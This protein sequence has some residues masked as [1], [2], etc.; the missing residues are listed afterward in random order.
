M[1][2]FVPEGLPEGAPL[3]V[4]L[5][6]CT[7]NAAGYDRGCGWSDL[8]RQLGFAL[9]LPEQ[10]QA[11][12]PNR[13]FNW[14]E[15]GDTARDAGEAA[16]IRQMVAHMLAAHRLDP[17]RVF[18]T[19]LSA[20]GA[21]TSVMLATYP[22]VFAAGAIIAG[23][24]H[25]AASNMQEAFEAMASGRPR[26]A[27]GWGDLVRAASPH[28]GP[29]PRVSVWQGEAD[30][31]VRPVN[32]EQILRQWT[33]LHG[34]SGA[35]VPEP[36]T[37]GHRHRVWR[38]AA[39]TILLESHSI[40]GMAHG[41]PIHPGEGE[42]RGGLAGPFILDAGISST[43]RIAAFFGL[44]GAPAAAAMPAR[45][46]VPAGIIAIGRDGEARL[47]A[48]AERPAPA[49]QAEAPAPYG[50]DPGRVIRRALEAAG[51]LKP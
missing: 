14:F 43:H 51:L 33:D 11:N 29:W 47:G 31:T 36:T 9:L 3:V 23:L 13:C 26:P 2:A 50:F 41:V 10:R 6:G 16:S 8:A 42:Q 17:R 4:A 46:V 22:E 15:P 21:M 40:A 1:F 48:R 32:A 19:G 37:D 49:G 24:P 44:G 20:G 39:G 27:R 12:N 34:H 45:S 30:S 18:V 38:D 25:G 35:P 7:Q 5:H 28:R